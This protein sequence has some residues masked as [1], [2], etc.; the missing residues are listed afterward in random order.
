MQEIPRR[1]VI[2]TTA[3][4]LN[5][6]DIRN[7]ISRNTVSGAVYDKSQL[8]DYNFV[9][10]HF[11]TVTSITDLTDSIL[12]PAEFIEKKSCNKQG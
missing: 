8:T 3:S 7:I 5:E 6:S 1:T 12:R 11:Y 4:K 2:L 10:S 9:R